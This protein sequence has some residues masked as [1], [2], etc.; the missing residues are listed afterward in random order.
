M[1]NL[2]TGGVSSKI[3]VEDNEHEI[4]ETKDPNPVDL[5]SSSTGGLQILLQQQVLRDGFRAFVS[6]H[7]IPSQ[8]NADFQHYAQT[9]PRK[10]A[11]SCVDF[12]TDAQDFGCLAAS[13]FHEYRA[14]HIYE[15]YIVH[16]CPHPAPLSTN[17]I[18][19]CSASLFCSKGK[20]D[21]AL[22]AC[23][24]TE[25][26]DFLI[27]EVFPAF[28]RTNLAIT[29][30]KHKLGTATEAL[31]S[32]GVALNSRRKSLFKSPDRVALT[33]MMAKILGDPTYLASFK[34]YMISAQAENYL[35]AYNDAVELRERIENLLQTDMCASSPPSPRTAGYQ[36]SCSSGDAGGSISSTGKS[37]VGEGKNV[38]RVISTSLT[39]SSPAQPPLIA[40]TPRT[41]LPGS[42]TA[43]CHIFFHYVNTFY[44]SYISLGARF[45]LQIPESVLNSFRLRL[46]RTAWVDPH[47]LQAIESFAFETLIR[48]HLDD[49]LNTK[50]YRYLVRKGRGSILI[51]AAGLQ[52]RVTGIDFVVRK[53]VAIAGS[54][55]YFGGTADKEN[56]HTTA[57]E[58]D[59]DLK[60]EAVDSIVEYGAG[61]VET[62]AELGMQTRTGP[63]PHDFPGKKSGMLTKVPDLSPLAGAVSAGTGAS[64]G[65]SVLT[66][67][68]L[69]TF[70][71]N[72]ST[73][74]GNR[75]HPASNLFVF[76]WQL[77][78]FRFETCCHVAFL[79]L[80]A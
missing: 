55:S 60:K 78:S 35:Y 13:A 46:A 32:L 23:A 47:I 56:T 40:L 37:F 66:R 11:L 65:S 76:S 71:S 69:K 1:G 21:P 72:P 6:L 30:P 34:T 53:Q 49:F 57:P 29:K 10:V 3:L 70:V 58:L 24:E 36:D 38:S 42:S 51:I 9:N 22:F 39:T 20:L 7:W 79:L 43:A 48:E 31:A 14:Y 2:I 18:D 12:W 64:V 5:R 26:L 77:A 33:A 15:K 19:D 28:E 75:M 16:G 8:N 59:D 27:A 62:A 68:E 52:D 41:N 80:F 17:T 63:A 50:E 45:R 54:N 74:S 4:S 61:G 67:M 25:V 73:H 44:D